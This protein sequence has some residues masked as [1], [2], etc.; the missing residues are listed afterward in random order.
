MRMIHILLRPVI[1]Q[2]KQGRRQF[3]TLNQK[4]GIV[5]RTFA[6][7]LLP[8]FFRSC[9]A[10][11]RDYGRH[12]HFLSLFLSLFIRPQCVCVLPRCAKGNQ[13]PIALSRAKVC[14]KHTSNEV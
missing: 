1:A 9:H 7:P 14:P 6:S 11:T 8:S 5:F 4:D 12:L 3:R 13:T 2:T 10:P